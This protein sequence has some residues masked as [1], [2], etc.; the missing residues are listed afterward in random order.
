MMKATLRR[1]QCDPTARNVDVRHLDSVTRG[2]TIY[3]PILRVRVSSRTAYRTRGKNYLR[4]PSVAFDR[5]MVGAIIHDSIE[6]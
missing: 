4:L 3:A 1:A 6:F 2:R 5:R